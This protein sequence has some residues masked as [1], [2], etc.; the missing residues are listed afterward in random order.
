MN[1]HVTVQTELQTPLNKSQMEIVRWLADGKS[2]PE[3]CEILVKSK[4]YVV[5]RMKEAYDKTGTHNPHGLVA[6]SLRRGW[7][8]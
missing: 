5:R 4:T 7:I 6:I 1:Q 3:I 8:Q 2:Y